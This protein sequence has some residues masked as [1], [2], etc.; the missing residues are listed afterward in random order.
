MV[1]KFKKLFLSQIILSQTSLSFRSFINIFYLINIVFINFNFAISF[2]KCKLEN[3]VVGEDVMCLTCNNGDYCSH[4]TCNNGS[5]SLCKTCKNNFFIDDDNPCCSPNSIPKLDSANSQNSNIQNVSQDPSVSTINANIADH[6]YRD[7]LTYACGAPRTVFIPR[8]QGANAAR[9]IVGWQP[10]FHKPVD[11]SGLLVT[12]QTV[13]YTQSFRPERIAQ[14]LFGSNTL[15]FTG[16]EVE[17]RTRCQVLADNF[18]LCP[19][20]V[21]KLQFKPFIENIIFE[22]QFFFAFNSLLPGAYA[23]V[24]LPLVHSRWSLGMCSESRTQTCAKFPACSVST[25]AS[26]GTNNLL[27]AVSGNYLFGEMQTPFK[28]GKITNQT[29]TLTKLACVDL[30]L[31]YDVWQDPNYYVGSF[32]EI[33]APT[34]N[35]PDNRYL[36]SPIIGN[37]HHWEFGAGIACNL[38][39]WICAE[40]RVILYIDA[41][42]THMFKSNQY[43]LFD[44]CAKGP[45]SRYTLLQEF[46][47]DDNYTGRL[48][49]GINFVHRP[50]HVSRTAKGDVVFKLAYSDSCLSFDVGYNFYAHTGESLRVSDC[51]SKYK[52]AFKADNICTQNTNPHFLSTSDL[53]LATGTSPATATHKVFMFIDYSFIERFACSRYLPYLGLGAELEVNAL[54]C[55]ERNNS[56]N[57]WGIWLKGGL[58][59]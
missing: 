53:A 20:F 28:Y 35:R 44:F 33:I 29:L 18:G 23:T 30:I 38:P 27:E 22:N 56:L 54:A 43:R 42:V 55:N 25:N 47:Q 9:Q 49:N 16:S 46:D 17:Y 7:C 8:S 37:G 21:G 15:T 19:N 11:W 31:G 40:Q 14:Y 51:P 41:H 57:Q 24:N 48:I 13:S 1:N 50:V 4:K 59:F 39:V 32:L 5:C 45:L 26:N 6:C 10:Y 36:F 2:A 12:G 58:V 34:G 3:R 52:Y